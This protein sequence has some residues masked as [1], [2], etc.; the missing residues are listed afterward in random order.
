MCQSLL[1]SNNCSVKNFVFSLSFRL[2]RFFTRESFHLDGFV[3]SDCGAVEEIMTTQNYT[4]T[5]QNTVAV[6]L[7]AGTDLEC[8]PFIYNILKKR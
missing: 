5:V 2:N 4:S 7:Y 6:A 8:A 3:V 1:S